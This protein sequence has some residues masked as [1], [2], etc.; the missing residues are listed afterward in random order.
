VPRAMTRTAQATCPQS[1]SAGQRPRGT[2]A[3]RAMRD[4]LRHAA[5]DVGP[6]SPMEAAMRPHSQRSN[7]GA[8]VHAGR[9]RLF[10]C[11]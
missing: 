6:V 8:S 4:L 9:V 1:V 2:A 3:K 10:V 11:R 5:D 7:T